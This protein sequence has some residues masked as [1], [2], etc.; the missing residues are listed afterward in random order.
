LSVYFIKITITQ[1]TE[2]R[3]ID[4]YDYPMS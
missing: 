2:N 3:T 1:K 4:D